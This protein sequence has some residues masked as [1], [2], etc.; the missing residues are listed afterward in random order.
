M[1]SA[2]KHIQNVIEKRNIYL[3][4]Y[5]KRTYF[6]IQIYDFRFLSETLV[7]RNKVSF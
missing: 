4:V 3:K 6:Q 7:I 1:H 5:E 2:L